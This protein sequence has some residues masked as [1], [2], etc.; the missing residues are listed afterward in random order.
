MHKES[1]HFSPTPRL[2]SRYLANSYLLC[3]LQRQVYF[4]QIAE[5]LG[6]ERPES[7]AEKYI[8]PFEFF[9]GI[10]QVPGNKVGQNRT[11]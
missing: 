11:H 10:E 1:S 7:R 4:S 8:E 3:F 5:D 6:R 9:G 2:P